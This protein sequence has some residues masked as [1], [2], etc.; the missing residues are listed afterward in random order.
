MQ[1]N[2]SQDYTTALKRRVVA[3]AAVVAPSPQ[4]R[5]NST[6]YTSLLANHATQRQRFIVPLQS[7]P[8]PPASFSSDCCDGSGGAI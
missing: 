2:S 1:V 3:K 4:K 6:L 7:Q 8:Q 5:K